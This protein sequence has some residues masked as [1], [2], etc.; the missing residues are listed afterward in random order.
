MPIILFP[1][2]EVSRTSRGW[3]QEAV[4]AQGCQDVHPAR[5]GPSRTVLA[6]NAMDR[7]GFG[8]LALLVMPINAAPAEVPTAV[9]RLCARATGGASK[10]NHRGPCGAS[11]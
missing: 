6:H 2:R 1:P 7:G 11:L 10:R 9:V 4:A 5:G 3:E 8:W